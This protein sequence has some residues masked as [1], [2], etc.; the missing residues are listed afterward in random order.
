MDN[1]KKIFYLIIILSRMYENNPMM[2]LLE[3]IF[4]IILSKTF[5]VIPK[6]IPL[7]KKKTSL[8]CV[9]E[10]SRPPTRWLKNILFF[11]GNV[12]N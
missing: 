11:H 3:K 2:I 5:D 1:P 4:G 7:K 8:C 12:S 10:N 9:K 6:R